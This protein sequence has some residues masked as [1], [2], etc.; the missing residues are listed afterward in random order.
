MGRAHCEA[1]PFFRDAF[2]TVFAHLD[3]DLERP[4]HEVMFA[5]E[6]SQDASL[7]DQTAFT[8]P[9]LFALEVALFRLLESFGLKPDLLLGHS[10]G[11][12]AAAH[13][14]GVLSLRDGCALVGARARLMQALR[15]HGAMVTSQASEQEV[16]ALI[17][18][19]ENCV[20][21]AALNG[22]MSIVLSGDAEAVQKI[23]VHFESMGRKATRL[24]VS[25]AFHSPHMDAMLETFHRVAETLTWHPAQI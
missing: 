5:A 17:A 15:R 23:A 13:L 11:E 16:S 3:G 19:Q 21:L 20:S 7:L 6:D 12:L 10:I 22:P 2:D 8:Q 1:F 25:H 4:L 24:K 9:A 18:G 14:A